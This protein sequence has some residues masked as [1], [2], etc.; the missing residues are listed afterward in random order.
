MP[1]PVP[2]STPTANPS[3]SPAPTSVGL[4]F[5][6][7][8]YMTTWNNYSISMNFTTY[9]EDYIAAK[10]AG[11]TWVP[12]GNKNFLFDVT[13]VSRETSQPVDFIVGGGADITFGGRGG[14]MATTPRGV[15]ATAPRRRR[16]RPRGVGAWTPPGAGTAR[17]RCSSTAA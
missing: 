6:T 9:T 2:T 8:S 3:S 12:P 17:S 16:D 10:R 13:L 15:D 1:S 14:D 5:E 7:P 11:T 4:S